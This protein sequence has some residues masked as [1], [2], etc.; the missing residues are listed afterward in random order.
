MV[1]DSIFGLPVH[2]LV[3]HAVVVLV[4]L[5]AVGVIVCAASP[6]WCERLATP[7]LAVLTVSVGAAFVAKF[8]GEEL[9]G[10]LPANSDIQQHADLGAVTPWVVL[11]FW[12]VV[13]AWLALERSRGREAGV[14]K[15]LLVMAVVSAFLATGQV[16]LTGHAGSRA[17]WQDVIESTNP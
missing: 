13:V 6:R 5:C 3:V 16:V 8:S 14:T 9:E 11:A 1:F 12:I 4:P 15:A 17:V 10:R 7:L 2:A